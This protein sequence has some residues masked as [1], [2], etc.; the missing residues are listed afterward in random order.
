MRK[1]I[2]PALYN[3][4]VDYGLIAALVLAVLAWVKTANLY[5]GL[6]VFGAGFIFLSIGFPML[7]HKLKKGLGR[8]GN[9]RK[10]R[11]SSLLYSVAMTVLGLAVIL[12]LYVLL[13]TGDAAL[14]ASAF[15]MVTILLLA[16]G[17]SEP[18]PGPE[19]SE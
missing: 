15:I 12:F 4:V 8:S 9:A 18:Q 5:M 6:A 16:G 14:G 19:D 17:C 7:D 1:G 11:D 13:K 3:L 2:P 10:M